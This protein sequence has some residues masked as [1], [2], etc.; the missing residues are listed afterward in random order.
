MAD[1]GLFE[2]RR[3]ELLDGEVMAM[4]PHGSA[5]AS[6]VARIMR[7]LAG[8]RQPRFLE[9]PVAAQRLSAER[10]PATARSRSASRWLAN[11]RSLAYD[12]GPKTTAY[13]KAGV[14]LLW[15]VDVRERCLEIDQDPEPD[16]GR[17]QRQERLAETD[18]V[19]IPRSESVAVSLLLPPR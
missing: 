15:I 11:A 3:V 17:Y 12:R 14:P 2:G 13:A 8:A 1:A 10:S 5:H 18:V 9:A 19:D 16:L 6:A 7:V 4:T